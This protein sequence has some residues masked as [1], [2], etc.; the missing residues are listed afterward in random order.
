MINAWVDACT[1][2]S[3]CV[4][5]C[6]CARMRAC[7]RVCALVGV[8]VCARVRA[9]AC[10]CAHEFVSHVFARCLPAIPINLITI[11]YLGRKRTL[12]LN[13]TITAV[14]FLLI[15]LCTGRFLL[16]MFIFGVRAFGSGIFN[17]VYIYTSEVSIPRPPA[18][19]YLI[20][21]NSRV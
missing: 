2:A 6:V 17:T 19:I 21:S 3:A 10:E 14:F 12:C 7:L 18:F 1:C 13:F 9:C 20:S 16:T 8:H 15:Q 11:D 5:A 4:C